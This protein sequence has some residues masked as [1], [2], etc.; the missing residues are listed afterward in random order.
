MKQLLMLMM[1]TMLSLIAYGN[2]YYLDPA[3][4][5]ITNDGSIDSPWGAFEEVINANLIVSNRYSPLPYNA[6]TSSLVP[7]NIN[8]VV[9]A[10][11]TLVLLDG[12]HG[13]VFLQNY[14][15]EFPVTIIG[16]EG[17]VPVIEKIRLQACKN[18]RFENVKVSTSDY[19]YFLNWRLFYIESHAHQGPSSNIEVHGCEIYSHSTPWTTAEEW[20]TQVSDG[21][22]IRADSVVV[23]DNILTNTKMGITAW[24]DYIRAENNQVINFSG[25]GMRL[26]GSHVIFESNLIKNCYDVDD[27]HDD[28]IQ[29]WTTN[30]IVVDD[31]QVIG[32]TIINTDDPSR[33]LNGP[34]Q[35]IG[36]FDGFYNNWVVANNVISVDHWH[37]ITFLGANNCQIINNTVIDLTPD[38]TP[39]ASWIRI[40]DH[41]NG[42]PSTGC[43]VANNVANQFVVDG[44]QLNNIVL[45]T[46]SEYEDNF[47]DYE[48]FDF[49][50]TPTSILIDAGDI[51]YATLFDIVN[52][53]R[54]ADD[55]PD[56]GAYEF[57]RPNAVGGIDQQVDIQ[58]FPNP[59]SEQVYLPEAEN[60]WV[61]ELYDAGGRRLFIVNYQ[62]LND[63]L[64][65]LAA[66]VYFLKITSQDDAAFLTVKTLIK[67]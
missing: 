44:E 42:A 66:G 30:G 39:G 67:G 60:D 41:K 9:H 6:V 4:G 62:G 37:G 14:I 3:N 56:V 55:S 2:K 61:F 26:L 32:N 59:F 24:G 7:K 16:E 29:S 48:N 15:N 17:H 33:P 22:Y 57:I 50:P 13:E 28:G 65:Q 35:G 12:L 64:G 52:N 27:N 51:D 11:D 34:L 1:L 23:T 25:D 45:N 46:Y 49:Y 54:F 58:L 31:N 36:C 20:L 47:T 53:D 19:G 5:S 40:D 10:G 38:I 8:G 63:D 21:L 43:V 18:W